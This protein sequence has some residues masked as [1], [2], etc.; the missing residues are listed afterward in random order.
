MENLSE[1]NEHSLPRNEQTAMEILFID[2]LLWSRP[3]YNHIDIDIQSLKIQS[4]GNRWYTLR[5][6]LIDY[7]YTSCNAITIISF[8][9]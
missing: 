9:K 2:G 4:A 5:E 8:H 7:S 6:M 3:F 1:M